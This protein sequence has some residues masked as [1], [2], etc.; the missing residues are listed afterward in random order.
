MNT[1]DVQLGNQRVPH[2]LH[3]PPLPPPLETRPQ[4][5]IYLLLC[6]RFFFFPFFISFRLAQLHT[7]TSTCGG[8]FVDERYPGSRERPIAAALATQ[9]C[10]VF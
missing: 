2:K 3:P 4:R 1:Y 6:L 7:S 9:T 5:E 10:A 8:G